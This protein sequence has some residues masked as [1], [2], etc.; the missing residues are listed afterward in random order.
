MCVKKRALGQCKRWWRWS[1]R[2]VALFLLAPAG[3]WFAGVSSAAESALQPPASAALPAAGLVDR[4]QPKSRVVIVHDPEATAAFEPRAERVIAMVHRAVTN[5]MHAPTVAAAWSRLVTTQDVV[6]IKVFCGPGASG[7]RPC[8]VAGVVEGLLAAGHPARQIVIWDGQRSDLRRA[9]YYELAE[10]YGVRVES[11]LAAGFDDNVFYDSPYLGQLVW[12]DHE[13][14]RKEA[15]VGRRSF[16]SKLVSQQITR[17]INVTP[18][19]NH[20]RAGVSGNLYGLAMDSVDNT[21]RFQMDAERLAVAVPEIYALP[22]LSD[23]V[24]LNIVDALLCQYQGEQQPLFHYSQPL[25]EIRVSRDPV[26]LDV[27]SLAALNEQR[28]MRGMR[29][30]TNHFELYHNASLLELG[31]SRL[32]EIKVERFE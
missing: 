15:G 2:T 22:V 26:A 3:T 30:L 17:L 13:F 9:G 19:L 1:V 11:S 12:G 10:R 23:R 28:Q 20:N 25:N 31:T 14:G 4:S 29:V 27:L 7:T 21:H 24:V 32:S 8:V 18:L 5:L 6:G 16:V